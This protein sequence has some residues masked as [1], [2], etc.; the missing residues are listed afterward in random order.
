M[1][2]WS[3]WRE[4]AVFVAV[5]IFPWYIALPLVV[6]GLWMDRLLRYLDAKEGDN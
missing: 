2:N 3:Q 1:N 4:N 6:I 5:L